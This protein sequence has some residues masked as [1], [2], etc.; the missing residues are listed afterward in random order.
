[1]P[2]K[3]RI[4]YEN[5]FYHVI[6]RGRGRQN[7]FHGEVYF[8]AFLD[9]LGEAHHRFGCLVNA[10]CLMSNHYHI[11][12]ETPNANLSRIMRHINGVYTQRYNHQFL[13]TGHFCS[14]P[15]HLAVTDEDF[16]S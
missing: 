12:I 13:R 15:K 10:Y 11:L 5:A 16:D 2:R 1:M 7:I 6:N 14:Q 8:R 3:P 9:T 4:E